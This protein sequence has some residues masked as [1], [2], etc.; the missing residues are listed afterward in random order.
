MIRS[1]VPRPSSV[2][3]RGAEILNK[4]LP[5]LDAFHR[6]SHDAHVSTKGMAFVGLHDLFG[7][8]YELA[9]AHLDEVKERVR[10]LGFSLDYDVAN[11][12]IATKLPEEATGEVLCETLFAAFGVYTAK[13]DAAY[14]EVNDLGLNGLAA[15]LQNRI[16]D[17]EKLGWQDVAHVS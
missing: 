14:E 10:V 11:A 13:L 3:K 6:L 2:R 12:T 5:D 7:R 9:F 15:V 8:V 4:L 16:A 17:F 1:C